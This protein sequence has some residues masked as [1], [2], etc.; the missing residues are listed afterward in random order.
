MAAKQPKPSKPTKPKKIATPFERWWTGTDLGLFR[1]CG[2][3]YSGYREETLP[4]LNAARL[5]GKFEWLTSKAKA[6]KPSEKLLK[7]L[8]GEAKAHGLTLPD[9]L[10]FLVQRRGLFDQIPSCTACEWDLGAELRPN[11]AEKG[12]FTFRLLRDQQD[13]YFWYLYLTP[14][15]SYVVGSP[16]PFDDDDVQVDKAVT[17]ANTAYVAPS[18]EHFA[19]RYWLENVLWNKLNGFSSDE[20]DYLSHYLKAL[21]A[22]QKAAKKPAKK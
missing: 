1:A 17:L 20:S 3:T 18:V 5:D 11:Q 13:C 12:A 6:V 15:G 22:P 4:P 16:I 21:T 14:K 9:D 2:G 8:E 10:R 7:K 19:Y